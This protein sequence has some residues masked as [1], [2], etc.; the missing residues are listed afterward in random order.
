MHPR[1][2]SE[3]PARSRVN[4]RTFFAGRVIY[5]EVYL[6]RLLKKVVNFFDEKV[7]PRQNPG[8]AYGMFLHLQSVHQKRPQ[9]V[10]KRRHLF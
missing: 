5:L 10:V 4:F 2:L 3:P 7:Y 8:Y 6:E 9:V 1:T